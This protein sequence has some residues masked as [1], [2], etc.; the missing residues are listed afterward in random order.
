MMMRLRKLCDV[1]R[2]W[3]ISAVATEVMVVHECRSYGYEGGLDPV[4]R[5]HIFDE[6]TCRG[7]GFVG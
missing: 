1:R 7:N 4:G 5:L 2:N 6:I 3:H